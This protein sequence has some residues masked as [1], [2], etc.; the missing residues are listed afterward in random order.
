MQGVDIDLLLLMDHAVRPQRPPLLRCEI[1]RNL[2]LRPAAPEPLDQVQVIGL[3]QPERQVD[4]VGILGEPRHAIDMSHKLQDVLLGSVAQEELHASAACPRCGMNR[5]GQV[6]RLRA[7]A[8]YK[9][10]RG[11]AGHVALREFARQGAHKLEDATI[12]AMMLAEGLEIPAEQRQVAPGMSNPVGIGIGVERIAGPAPV[13]EA[14]AHIVAQIEVTCEQIRLVRCRG[15]LIERS[16]IGGAPL[17]RPHLLA[18]DGQRVGTVITIAIEVGRLAPAHHPRAPIHH[19]AMKA[20]HVERVVERSRHAHLGCIGHNRALAEYLLQFAGHLLHTHDKGRQIE[21]EQEAMIGFD[22]DQ[23]HILL[24]HQFAKQAEQRG[25]PGTR[26]AHKGEREA[27]REPQPLAYQF[28]EH[29][30]RRVVAV[31]RNLS[32]VAL[33]HALIKKTTRDVLNRRST[34]DRLRGQ[35]Q[36]ARLMH[37]GINR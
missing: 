24:R 35:L 5:Q 17:A 13:G 32:K 33:V 12:A 4:Q 8:L 10:A 27:N 15:R 25:V 31:L 28:Q 11:I 9:L 6:I 18:I 1:G 34:R 26:L 36:A 29:A 16:I 19:S 30:P 23:F 3:R 2:R 20:C 21:Q 37:H 14:I 22:A 7:V